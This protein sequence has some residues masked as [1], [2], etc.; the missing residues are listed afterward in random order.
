MRSSDF[1]NKAK[2]AAVRVLGENIDACD[3]EIVW[4]T[5]TLGHKKCMICGEPMGDRYAEVTYNSR[6]FELYVDIY[7]KVLHREYELRLPAIRPYVD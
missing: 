4:L 1:E 5:Q 2:D 6:T 3:L 7:C